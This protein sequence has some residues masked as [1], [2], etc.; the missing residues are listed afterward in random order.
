MVKKITIAILTFIMIISSCNTIN[1]AQITEDGGTASIPIRYS[2][3][4]T[5]F[6]ITIPAIII[7]DT[8][9]SSFMVSADYMNIRPDEHVE[10]SITKGCDIDSKV[11]LT[12]QNVTAD[13][14]A[15]TLDTYLSLSN[16]AVSENNYVVGYFKD[17]LVSTENILGKVYMSALEIDSNTPAG[18]YASVIEFTVDLRSDVDE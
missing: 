5:A 18:D 13:K 4:N 11:T 3:N 2:V 6:I 10:V 17:S 14:M 12:R 8:K 1:A 9:E 7:P 15:D 16:Q